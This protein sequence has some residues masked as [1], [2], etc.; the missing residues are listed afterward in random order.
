MK[1]RCMRIWP[2]S[3]FC[4][5][6][7]VVAE[8][9]QYLFPGSDGHGLIPPDGRRSFARVPHPKSLNLRGFSTHLRLEGRTGPD[10]CR[11]SG[12]YQ[13][14]CCASEPTQTVVVSAMGVKSFCR[15]ASRPRNMTARA[16]VGV[17]ISGRQDESGRL[18]C[19]LVTNQKGLVATRNEAGTL[20]SFGK[21]NR[22]G[23]HLRKG[24]N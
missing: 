15:T 14:V 5:R 24:P 4:K 2:P 13:M 17:K 23:V 12:W 21:R 10:C 3:F 7:F 6:V 16:L 1:H 8:E 9:T 18:I 19:P 22:K 11:L 20:G